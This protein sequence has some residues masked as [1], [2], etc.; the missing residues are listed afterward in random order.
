MCKHPCVCADMYAGL[1]NHTIWQWGQYCLRTC[2]VGPKSPAVV[3]AMVRMASK[4]LVEE[5]LGHKPREREFEAQRRYDELS[6]FYVVAN[7]YEQ[8]S[9][10]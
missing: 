2:V 9:Y 5:L 3:E 1:A 8:G 6:R 4:H 7:R 10:W